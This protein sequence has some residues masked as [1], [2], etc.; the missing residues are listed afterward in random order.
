MKTTRLPL[1]LAGFLSLAS[2]LHA[3]TITSGVP[4]L[5]SYQGRVLDSTGAPV[6][7]TTTGTPVNRTVTFR[8]WNHASNT[9]STNLIYS[10]QQVVTIADGNFSVLVGQGVATAGSQ[11]PFSENDYGPGASPPVS[12]ANAFGGSERYLGVTVDDANGA[13]V[14][15]EIAPRQQVVSS[16]FALRSKVAESLTTGSSGATT[17]TTIA[18]GSIGVSGPNTLITTI[19]PQFLVTADDVSERLRIGVDSTGNGTSFLQSWKEG[20]GAT[21][22]LLNP[23][24]GNVGVRTGTTAPLAQLQVGSLGFTHS[25]PLFQVGDTTLG[26]ALGSTTTLG[27]FNFLSGNQSALSVRAVRSIAGGDWQHT[28]VTLSHDVDG[29][30]GAGGILSIGRRNVTIGTTAPLHPAKLFVHNDFAPTDSAIF[31][32]PG[33][34]PVASHIHYG[35]NG[36][37]YWRSASS[38]G[39]VILQDTGG[40]V[41]IGTSSPTVAK[42][43]VSG[44][45]GSE[46][47]G[48]HYTYANTGV[49]AAPG[50]Y[51]GIGGISIKASDAVHAAFYRALSDARIKVIEG[52]SNGVAD[53]AMLSR[54]EITDYTHKD[55]IGKGKDRSKKVIAQQVEKVFPQAVTKTVDVVPDIYKAAKIVDGWI[56]LTTDLKKGERVRLIGEK[57]DEIHEVLE[58]EKDRFLTAY[59]PDPKSDAKAPGS[60]IASAPSAD[61]PKDDSKTKAARKDKAGKDQSADEANRIFVFGREVK[62]FRVVDYEAIAMLNVSATQ[63]LARKLAASEAAVKALQ[64]ENATLREQEET[65]AKRLAEMTATDKAFEA[66]LTALEKRLSA[67]KTALQTVSTQ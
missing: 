40:N 19:N 62:D 26:S 39:K 36:D 58:V 6:G 51:P 48:S 34:G 14:D 38:A 10:E 30:V 59:R 2:L 41:G 7:D 45:G 4:G 32:S 21:N 64:K 37:V 17:L 9:G 44:T 60:P 67:G 25:S 35:P 65:N 33:A 52:V 16:A 43:V 24:G 56:E 12:I 49:I 5:I 15:S 3:Q 55:V 22:L 61:A 63:E 28:V 1:L 31:Y 53:L 50:S 54:I 8:V 29:N 11:F 23:N 66:K 46:N 20:T 47:L 42:L 57:H 27:S 18:G 13:T